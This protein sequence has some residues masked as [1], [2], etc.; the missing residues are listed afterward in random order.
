[1][2][3]WIDISL[4]LT[5]HWQLWDYITL[6]DITLASLRLDIDIIYLQHISFH[7][8]RHILPLAHY[9][10]HI[11]YYTLAIF[12]IL[13]TQIT[14]ILHTFILQSHLHGISQQP[15]YWLH[16][17]Y[18]SLRHYTAFIIIIYLADY[19]L[20]YWYYWYY[21]TL[22]RHYASHYAIIRYLALHTLILLLIRWYYY[23][24]H[25][26]SIFRYFDDIPL[27]IFL[28]TPLLILPLLF[29]LMIYY[30]YWLADFIIDYAID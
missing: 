6:I 15:L 25:Y 9:W 7:W 29:L 14:F 3:H 26:I 22:L 24:C 12:I 5:F 8:L 2:P 11:R 30:W 27:D 17:D 20:H 23:W 19:W 28:I 18:W 10:L 13:I 1:L 4:S 21:Y 16:Y